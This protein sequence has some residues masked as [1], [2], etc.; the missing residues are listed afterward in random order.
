M[1]PHVLLD[2]AGEP[3]GVRTHVFVFIAAANQL[4]RRTKLQPIFLRALVPAKKS[5]HDR[6][7]STKRDARKAGSGG[8]REA[9]KIDEHSFVEGGIV[10]RQNADCAAIGE[11]FE[12]RARGPILVDWLIAGEAAKT[13]D[14]RVDARV[15]DR[16]NEKVQ[17]MS[18]ERVRK[19]R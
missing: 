2:E 6:S 7:V 19:W 15:L 12:H 8:C 16:P 4:H 14:Q 11:D 13:I 5:G 10:V 9:E 1:R 18:V 17:R 3:L